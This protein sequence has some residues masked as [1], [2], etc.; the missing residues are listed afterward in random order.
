[1]DD[2]KRLSMEVGDPS[3]ELLAPDNQ[4]VNNSSNNSSKS[5]KSWRSFVGRLTR[6]MSTAVAPKTYDEIRSGRPSFLSSRWWT[7]QQYSLIVVVVGS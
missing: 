2:Y 5:S 4:H 3:E 1:M 7:E 6:G